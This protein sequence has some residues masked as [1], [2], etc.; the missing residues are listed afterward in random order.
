[1]V[2]STVYSLR[3]VERLLGVSDDTLKRWLRSGRIRGFRLPGQ[4][5]PWRIE[6]SEV[7]RI[8]AE[9]RMEGPR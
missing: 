4:N 9:G 2:V 8:K 3:E 7:A 6:D 5:G 1:M